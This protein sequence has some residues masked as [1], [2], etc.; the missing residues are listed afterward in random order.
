MSLSLPH[1]HRLPHLT[2]RIP[3]IVEE[4]LHSCCPDAVQNRSAYLRHA[5]RHFDPA[6][7]PVFG[8][9]ELVNRFGKAITHSSIRLMAR[10][11]AE[12]ASKIQIAEAR[13]QQSVS[14]NALVVS[15]VV[16]HLCTGAGSRLT[17]QGSSVVVVP[18]GLNIP[19][20]LL[21]SFFEAPFSS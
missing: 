17:S 16:A 4:T 14:L 8:T 15:A 13:A 9:R 3:A 21:Q 18:K 12:W 11:Q 20:S 5:V 6:R 2:V 19:F 10:E 7:M 1:T